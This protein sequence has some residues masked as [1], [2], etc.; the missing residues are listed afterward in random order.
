M[1]NTMAVACMNKMGTGHSDSC[2][3][4]TKHFWN[5]LELF[6]LTGISGYQPH[7]CQAKRM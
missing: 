3:A 2:N 5:F 7:M 6:A 1:G 4:F